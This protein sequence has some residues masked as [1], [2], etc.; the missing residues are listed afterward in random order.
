MAGIV[1]LAFF[2]LVGKILSTNSA[3]RKE[4]RRTAEIQ[5]IKL[6]QKRQNEEAKAYVAEQKRIA[7]EQ[8]RQA[9]EQ[10][11][12]AKEQTKQAEM[13]AKHEKRI[14]DLEFRMGQAERDKDFLYDRIVDLEDQISYYAN[15][16]D[17]TTYGSADFEKYQRKIITLK[18]QKNSA[19]ARMEKAQHTIDMARKELEVA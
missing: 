11:R 10:E 7:S 15:K 6:E 16:Q 12:L 8:A 13:L 14:A 9:K 1:I 5:R 18:N 3:E 19:L 4:Q 2:W 17:G